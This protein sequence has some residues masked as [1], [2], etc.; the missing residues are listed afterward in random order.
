MKRVRQVILENL[1]EG[2]EEKMNWGMIHIQVPYL[3]IQIHTI[4][5]Q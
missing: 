4:N 5:S 2:Y 3:F 1:P